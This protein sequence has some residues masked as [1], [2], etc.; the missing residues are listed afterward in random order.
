M[1]TKPK[2]YLTFHYGLTIFLSAFLL[3]QVQP[4]IG[5]MI[6]P[7][8][9][10]SASVW[11]T[12]MLFFQVLLLLGYSYS[13]FV[14][15]LLTA[16]RQSYLHIGLLLLSL[17]CLPL[18]P[19]ADWRP[20]GAEN[21]TLR[22]LLLLCASIG[23]P[24]FVLSTTGPLIQA[25]F[26]RER[27]GTVPYRLFALSN[28]G[29]L[30]ALLAY[31]VLVEPGLPTRW[32]SLG[33]SAL[34][35]CFV[36]SCAL[37]AWRGRLGEAGPT[38]QVAVSG[39]A[40]D[41]PGWAARLTWVA[42]AACPSVLLIADTSFLTENVAPIPLLWVL[43]LAI[44][45]LS[46]IFCFERKGWYQRRVF[47]PLL[48]VGIGAMAYLPTLGLNAMP[49][50]LAM[51]VNL[52]AFFVVCM[53][54]HGEVAALQPHPSHLTTY[55]L[56]LATGG[57]CG[58]LFVGLI[59]PYCFNSNY[60]YSIGLVLTVVVVSLVLI[61]RH[62]PPGQRRLASSVAVALTLMTAYIRV[63]DHLEDLHGAR[64]LVRNF[65]GAQGVYD[66]GR[67][68]DAHRT[69]MH[70]QIIHGKQYT[71]AERIDWP[72]T[73]YSHASGVGR[74]LLAKAAHGPLRVGLVGLGAGTLASYGRLGDQYRIYEIDPLVVRLA[75]QEFSFLSRSPAS[76][77]IVLGDARLTL[78]REA[79]QQFDVLVIDAFSGDSVPVHLLTREAFASYFRH[80]KPDGVLAIHVTNRFLN[81]PPVVKAAADSFGKAARLVIN[82]GDRSREIYR[83]SWA[84]L[85]GDPALFQS[86]D[87]AGVA[88]PIPTPVNFRIWSDDYSSVFAVL[89]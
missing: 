61:L 42:L 7:W 35:V 19:S 26:A 3:F 86:A 87:L 75:R 78:E 1:Q 37:L 36:A 6:L 31:P 57:A 88:E 79:S 13:H 54:C 59:A 20:T 40:A 64:V 11:T 76:T 62:L 9:G 32:Q 48:V 70:G 80:L 23:L 50:L 56:M 53:V 29:S 65:Y 51:A 28:L 66:V 68:A 67:G 82:E 45:L 44:Y 77:A 85:T 25:W 18:A 71:T 30:L 81:L 72:T 17:L 8:F 21:P 38:I 83:S 39:S 15:R 4:M 33:W 24:Y 43:P 34:F 16:R 12:C 2:R 22:I 55:Y 74:A 46:F 47:L 49:V 84:L 73:Y 60:E 5:K 89:K 10:G 27:P 52:A 69:L 41:T 63:D 58:G 14:M